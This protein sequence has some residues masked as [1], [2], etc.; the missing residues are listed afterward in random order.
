MTI[1]WSHILIVMKDFHFFIL[2]T[3]FGRNVPSSVEKYRAAIR[4]LH[5]SKM[6]QDTNAGHT[7]SV[8]GMFWMTRVRVMAC[9]CREMTLF[10]KMATLNARLLHLAKAVTVVQGAFSTQF[11]RK[12]P[13]RFHFLGV[14]WFQARTRSTTASG[15]ESRTA[16]LTSKMHLFCSNV[17][18]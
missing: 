11:R 16:P 17:L 14:L 2:T 13:W 6:I 4:D 18:R 3:H 8:N 15:T 12:P 10:L 5:T 7:T 9:H 1:L